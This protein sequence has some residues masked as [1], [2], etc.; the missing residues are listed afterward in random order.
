[1]QLVIADTGRVNYP[2]LI[3]HLDLLPVLF[4]KVILPA[5]VHGELISP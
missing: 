2:I 1:V 4:D 3:G 5:A